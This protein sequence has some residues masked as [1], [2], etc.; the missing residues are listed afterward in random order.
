MKNIPC[1]GWVEYW[2]EVTM[3]APRSNRNSGHRRDDPGTVGT[4]DQQ[5]RGVVG[6]RAGSAGA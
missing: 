2:S 3:F 1:S 6:A 4:G 5:P